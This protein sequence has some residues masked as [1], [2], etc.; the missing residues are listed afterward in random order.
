MCSGHKPVRAFQASFNNWMKR[1]SRPIR[2][3]RL[4]AV[5]NREMC[6]IYRVSQRNENLNKFPFD[7]VVSMNYKPTHLVIRRLNKCILSV[8]DRSKTTACWVD[9]QVIGQINILTR[10]SA[11]SQKSC[12]CCALPWCQESFGNKF[13]KL[14]QN[15]LVI[16]LIFFLLLC[17]LFMFTVFLLKGRNSK[18]INVRFSLDFY[19]VSSEFEV[20]LYEE[21]RFLL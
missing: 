7:K 16:V 19:T 8:V 3:W 13:R 10:V 21:E 1:D 14:K 15:C 17:F 11:F 2:G 9:E 12:L 18:G 20:L 6:S 5:P 4:Y